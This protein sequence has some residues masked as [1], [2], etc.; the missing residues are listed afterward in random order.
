MSASNAGR[1]GVWGAS[2]SGKSTYVK[3]MIAT[4]RRVIVLDPMAEY[5]KGGL[6][7]A[8]SVEAVRK[9]MVKDWTGFRIALAPRAG[10]EADYLNSLCHLI[11][12]AQKPYVDGKSKL[13]LSLVV[14]EMN[15]AFPVH[16]GERKCPMFADMC[17]RGR[18]FG[19]E[20]IGVSQRMAEVSTRF[21]GNC[22][23]TVILRQQGKNDLNTSA[24]TTGIDVAKLRALKNLE[25]LHY[26]AGDVTAGKL[27]F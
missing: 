15:T 12:M 17:S 7:Q 1:I 3:R 23:E 22:T 27:T 20:I 6:S 16:G 8:S 24:E 2:G 14:E 5:S 4:R 18:H 10:R 11:L 26:K 21:R 25:F 9:A 19:V 13:G